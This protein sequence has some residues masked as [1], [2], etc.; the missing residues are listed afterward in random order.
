MSTVISSI[1]LDADE[2][3]VYI[4][5]WIKGPLQITIGDRLPV[6]FCKGIKRLHPEL[7]KKRPEVIVGVSKSR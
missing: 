3:F 6:R 1:S 4:T 7:A 5:L 2:N